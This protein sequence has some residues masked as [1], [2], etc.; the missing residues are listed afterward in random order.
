MKRGKGRGTARKVSWIS[1]M[2]GGL[3]KKEH[4]RWAGEETRLGSMLHVDNEP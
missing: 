2:D 3:A 4:V 1:D